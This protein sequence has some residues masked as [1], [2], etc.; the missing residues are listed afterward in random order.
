MTDHPTT[1]RAEPGGDERLDWDDRASI[2]HADDGG[3]VL[4]GMKALHR[5]TLA[6]MVTMVRNMPE[7][8]R[9]GLVIEKA[10]DRR[11]DLPEILALAEREDFP[12]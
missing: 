3:G 10:G 4:D 1:F 2:H 11:I 6:Q 7:D 8:R 5:G 12:G 9:S